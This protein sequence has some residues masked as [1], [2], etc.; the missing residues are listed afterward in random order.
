MN[1]NRRYDN[2]ADTPYTV[3]PAERVKA[4][5]EG[6]TLG[7]EDEF[8]YFFRCGYE[9]FNLE[10]NEH[11]GAMHYAGSYHPDGF[12]VGPGICRFCGRTLFDD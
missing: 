10:S 4:L 2:S 5:C 9:E 11:H 12:C 7:P 1:D 3:N 6:I 8:S